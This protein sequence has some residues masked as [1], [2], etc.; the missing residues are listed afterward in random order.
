MP[1]RP[2]AASLLL[3]SVAVASTGCFSLSLGGRTCT[4][5]SPETIARITALE[6]RIS[7]LEQM[8]PPPVETIMPA[9]GP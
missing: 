3:A 2:F 6:E 9:H 8:L 5:T 4:G 7:V 1:V